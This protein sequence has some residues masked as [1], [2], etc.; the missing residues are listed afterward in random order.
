MGRFLDR[1]IQPSDLS[2]PEIQ[3]LDLQDVITHK[4][5]AAFDLVKEPL[6]LDDVA[7]IIE[8]MNKLPGPFIKYF[9]EEIGTQK[10]CEI[11]DL[12]ETRNATAQ[13]MIGYH[14]GQQMHFFKGEI[15]GTISKK[16]DGEKGFGWDEIFIPIGHTKIRA[17]MDEKEYD[18]TSPRRIALD[19]LKEFIEAH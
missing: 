1:E 5:Q 4:T 16:P 15:K 3:S 11:V 17:E 9:I 19:K 18:L 8:G 13:T 6:F 12:Y 10:L 7:L 14:D 2:I